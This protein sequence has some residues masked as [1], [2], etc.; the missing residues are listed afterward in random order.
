MPVASVRI[1]SQRRETVGEGSTMKGRIARRLGKN[2]GGV[3]KDAK[4]IAGRRA[5]R[6]LDGAGR[7]LRRLGV[8]PA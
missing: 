7:T 1:L 3:K 2:R 4:R 6:V 8:L 5:R